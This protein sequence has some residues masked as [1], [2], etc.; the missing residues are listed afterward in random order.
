[1]KSKKPK[2]KNVEIVRRKIDPTPFVFFILL[3]YFIV[4]IVLLTTKGISNDLG[5][6]GIFLLFNTVLIFYMYSRIDLFNVSYHSAKL[7][8][9]TGEVFED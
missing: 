2:L 9:E 4:G 3:I 6:F 8:E 1:M 7:N 5:L